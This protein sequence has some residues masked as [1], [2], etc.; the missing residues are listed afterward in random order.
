MRTLLLSRSYLVLL[1]FLLIYS[2]ICTQIPLFNYLG[3]EFSALSGIVVSFLAGFYLLH[4]RKKSQVV[5]SLIPFFLKLCAA[6]LIALVIPISILSLNA[7]W[8]KNCSYIQ[9]VKLFGVI[10]IPS[11][12]F[13]T[14]LSLLISSVFSRLWK[15]SFIVIFL[16]LLA[17]IVFET[18]AK[19]QIYSFNHIIGFFPGVTYDEKLDFESR[20]LIYRISTFAWTL[21]F[22]ASAEITFCLKRGPQKTIGFLNRLKAATV[23][24]KE[25]LLLGF[26]GLLIFY[27][28]LYSEE[29]QL[30][31]SKESLRKDLG[32]IYETEKIIL[33]YPKNKL[34]VEEAEDL[35]RLH[36]FYITQIAME[37]RTLQIRKIESYVYESSDQ[38]GRLIGASGTNIA[39]PWLW[40]VHI[41]LQDVPQSLKHELVHVMAAEFGFPL[42]RIGLNPGLIEGTA[43]A[44]ERTAYDETIHHLAAQAFDIGLNPK[45]DDLFSV[46]GFIRTQPALSYPLAGSFCRFLIDQFGI[47]KF[48]LLY[49]TGDFKDVYNKDL[50]RLVWEWRRLLNRYAITPE[51]REKA[52]YLF[53]RPSI[54]TKECARVL[55]DL[56]S[57]SRQF[58]DEGRFEEALEKSQEVLRLSNNPVAIMT[59]ATALFKLKQ[60]E[61]CADLIT[62]ASR[63]STMRRLLLPLM[64]MLGDTYWALGDLSAARTEYERAKSIL[65]QGSHE[66]SAEVRL[67]AISS[68]PNNSLLRSY[69]VEHQPD[70]VRIKTL[71][72]LIGGKEIQSPLLYYLL[73]REKMAKKDYQSAVALFQDSGSIGSPVLE[74]WRLYRLGRCFYELKNYKE[75][76]LNFLKARDAAQQQVHH[77]QIQEWI[78]RCEWMNARDQTKI[79]T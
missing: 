36:D 58:L 23:K 59:G 45:M 10:V 4:I 54:F 19:P 73:A 77:L 12:F 70:S 17:G 29:L 18:F 6:L 64:M 79:T 72:A 66:E 33:I 55:A 61:E 20:L 69:F 8:V 50:N 1:L 67:L 9:G 48:K 3:F 56:N 7:I 76:K 39:K 68:F 21:F 47:R 13:T 28:G 75:A 49:R 32:G 16:F 57:K 74:Q 15:T 53:K 51:K 31:S 34:S 62:G 30:S 38:K 65:I 42:L 22:L 40:Q 46:M 52:E 43:M 44:V 25:I 63:D 71:E 11:L 35:A 24:W 14:S 60:Y 37:L 2:I 27:F 41:N 78:L 26:S 5:D